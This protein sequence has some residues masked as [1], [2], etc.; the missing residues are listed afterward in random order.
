MK[1]KFNS[2]EELPDLI[3]QGGKYKEFVEQFMASEIGISEFTNS[4]KD[5]GINPISFSH[6]IKYEIGRLGIRNKVFVANRSKRFFIVNIEK[7]GIRYSNGRRKMN[8]A[9][10]SD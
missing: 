10:R 5:Y 4:K 3:R 2:V 8:A 7:T 1:F 9:G 6:G